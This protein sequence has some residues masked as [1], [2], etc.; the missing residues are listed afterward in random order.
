MS[1]AGRSGEEKDCFCDQ[2]FRMTAAGNGWCNSHYD[3][4]SAEEYIPVS[5]LIVVQGSQWADKHKGER[6]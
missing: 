6:R 5:K 3:S 2:M 1:K 4:I